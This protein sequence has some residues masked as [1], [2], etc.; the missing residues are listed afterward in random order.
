M[1]ETRHMFG[2]YMYCADQWR[3][4]NKLCRQ[5]T[6]SAM[7]SEVWAE[8]KRAQHSFHIECAIT[9]R[10]RTTTPDVPLRMTSEYSFCAG[11]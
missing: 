5:L 8:L 10:P 1:T 11:H 9:P 6:A 2:F 7:Q 3:E 4:A